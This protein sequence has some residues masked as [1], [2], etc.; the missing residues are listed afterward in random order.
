[1]QQIFMPNENERGTVAYSCYRFTRA[2]LM[3]K[4]T[5]S[6]LSF[7]YQLLICPLGTGDKTNIFFIMDEMKHNGFRLGK[8]TL[9]KFHLSNSE[10]IVASIV[11]G[12]ITA[13]ILGY[14]YCN[15]YGIYNV[16]HIDSTTQI[17]ENK[18]I[19]AKVHIPTFGRQI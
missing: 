15:Y 19:S 4:H 10:I 11:V 1:M 12:T 17:T 7:L 13:L 8:D 3:N 14:V 2:F 5:V 9:R 16:R 18:H 6:T